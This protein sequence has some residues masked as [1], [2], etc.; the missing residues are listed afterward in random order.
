MDIRTDPELYEHKLH[1]CIEY[2]SVFPSSEF[3]MEKKLSTLPTLR[4]QRTAHTNDK[5]K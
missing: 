4:L 5:I 1:I 3:R 2:H